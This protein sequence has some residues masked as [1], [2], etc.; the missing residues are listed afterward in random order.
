[1][2][3]CYPAITERNES[4]VDGVPRYEPPFSNAKGP[5]AHRSRADHGSTRCGQRR[6]VLVGISGQR[7]RRLLHRERCDG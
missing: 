4:I 3:L 7:E 6:P 5:D 2:T 1:M